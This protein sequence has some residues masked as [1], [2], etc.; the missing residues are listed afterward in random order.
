MKQQRKGYGSGFTLIEMMITVAVVAILAA[1]ALPSYREYVRRGERAEAKST[2]LQMQNWMQQQ[3]TLNNQYPLALGAAP[4]TLLQSPPTGTAKYNI[5]LA[6][7]AA[8][9]YTLQAVPA[10]ADAKCGTLTITN[11]GVRA[12]GGSDNVNYCWER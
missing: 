8:Q 1:I 5:S 3:Y 11:S 6:V 4:A 7:A 10:V 12:N 9:T 2:M